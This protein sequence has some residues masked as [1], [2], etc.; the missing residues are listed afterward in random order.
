MEHGIIVGSQR[1]AAPQELAIYCVHLTK[2]RMITRSSISKASILDRVYG[3]HRKG[4]YDFLVSQLVGN[5][6]S[7]KKRRKA[8]AHVVAT[9][10]SSRRLVW[11]ENVGMFVCQK[12]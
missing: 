9:A 2:N 10:E 7:L 1:A 6:S 5:P 4:A 8:S 12:R 11:D 3:G